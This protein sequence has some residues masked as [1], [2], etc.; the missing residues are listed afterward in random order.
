MIHVFDFIATWQKEKLYILYE[1]IRQ[2][3]NNDSIKNTLTK[4]LFWYKFSVYVERMYTKF[5]LVHA[6]LVYQSL[7]W[8]RKPT[9]K[10]HFWVDEEEWQSNKYRW[11]LW[12]EQWYR[13][14][15]DLKS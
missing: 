11:L 7:I 14:Q 13:Y 12:K 8:G 2:Y 15:R 9:P 5:N 4:Y 6:A 10:M 3:I 1:M